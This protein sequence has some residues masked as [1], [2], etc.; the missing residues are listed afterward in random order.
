MK[1]R[2]VLV[3]SEGN[4]IENKRSLLPLDVPRKSPPASG[5][6]LIRVGP[7][8]GVY[9][10]R[11]GYGVNGHW[12]FEE[13]MFQSGEFGFIYLIRDRLNERMYIGKKQF[14][15]SGSKNRGIETNWATYVSSCKDLVKQ[16]REHG[17]ELFDFYVLEQYKIRGTLGYAETWSLMFVE[18]PVNR[19]KWYNGLVNKVSWKVSEGISKRHK[20]RLGLIL[21]GKFDQLKEYKEDNAE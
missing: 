8:S 2:K 16:I 18:T 15:G 4:I 3:D 20:E 1:I 10:R 7:P 21:E 6:R 11:A 14:L 9:T 19:D 5:L 12:K 17:R 13:P